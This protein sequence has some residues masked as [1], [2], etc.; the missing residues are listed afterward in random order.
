MSNGEGVILAL[1]VQSGEAQDAS[2]CTKFYGQWMPPAR[3]PHRSTNSDKGL[4][5]N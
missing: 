5:L 2:K 3:S 1:L 4:H